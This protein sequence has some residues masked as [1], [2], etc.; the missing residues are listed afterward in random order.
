MANSTITFNHGIDSFVE[1]LIYVSQCLERLAN[2][3][4]PDDYFFSVTEDQ[5]EGLAEMRDARE[6]NHFAREIAME[7]DARE[8]PEYN[9]EQLDA[10]LWAKVQTIKPTD[11]DQYSMTLIEQ[12]A[13]KDERD[14]LRKA[15]VVAVHFIEDVAHDD[16]ARADKFFEARVLWRKAFALSPINPTEV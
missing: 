5:I 6:L 8:Y 16:P 7:F 4:T 10:L 14:A 2:G 12:R 9:I 3:E 1:A 11:T 15:L 13:V